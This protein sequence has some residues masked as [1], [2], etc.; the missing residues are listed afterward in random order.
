M[1]ADPRAPDAAERLRLKPRNSES[2]FVDGAWWPRSRD[3][4]TEVPELATALNGRNGPVWRVAFQ[5]SAWAGTVRELIFHGRLVKLEGIDSQNV[6]VVHVTGGN[7]YRL[8]LLVIPPEADPVA[9]ERVLVA[10][11]GQNS[12]ACPEA[13]LDEFGARP[14]PENAL[15]RWESEGGHGDTAGTGA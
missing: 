15:A 2:G 8:T 10:A 1:C 14:A 5:P 12:V 11:S 6:H 13:L 7:M 3:L 9:A 4:T